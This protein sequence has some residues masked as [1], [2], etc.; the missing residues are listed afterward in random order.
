MLADIEQRVGSLEF[1]M[2]ELAYQQLK[3]DM[4]LHSLSEEMKDFKDEM[5]GY[6]S[7][8]KFFTLKPK[9]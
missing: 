2:K 7:I 6:N 5:R 8:I 3:T 4:S 9:S 1:Y